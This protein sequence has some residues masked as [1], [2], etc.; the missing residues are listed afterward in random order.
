[1][2]VVFVENVASARIGDVKEVKNGY[3]RNF[4]LPRGMALPATETFVERAQARAR[5][6]GRRQVQLDRQ[7]QTLADAIAGK[8]ITLTARV[9]ETGRLYGSVTASDIAEA[10]TALAGTEID[11]HTIELAEPIRQVGEY[12][13][14]VRL[15]RNVSAD[16][17]VH[18]AAQDEEAASDA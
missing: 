7:A 1:M 8:P 10:L 6:E 15:T 9:G 12:S 2:K 13:V 14:H 11:R 3:A 16:V 17:Q 5:A 4:L 18:V